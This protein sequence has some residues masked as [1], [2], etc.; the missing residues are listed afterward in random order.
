MGNRGIERTVFEL[1]D[2]D[3]SKQAGEAALRILRGEAVIIDGI[4]LG[5]DS[6]GA[7]RKALKIR[8]Q[9]LTRQNPLQKRQRPKI[10]SF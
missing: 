5:A 7:F 1:T 2:K 9:A 8:A 3:S 4:P 6:P 10:S